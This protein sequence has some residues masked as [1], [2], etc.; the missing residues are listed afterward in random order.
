MIHDLA[1]HEWLI[2]ANR[3]LGKL[4]QYPHPLRAETV[5]VL[6]DAVESIARG[7]QPATNALEKSCSTAQRHHRGGHGL[8]HYHRAAA[9]VRHHQLHRARG[10]LVD[11][12]RTGPVPAD[13]RRT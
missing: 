9:A 4:V 5:D 1:W 10:R 12:Q 7:D 11:R 8:E 3:L 6:T 13:P 2:D